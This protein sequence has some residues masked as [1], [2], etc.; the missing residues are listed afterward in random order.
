MFLRFETRDWLIDDRRKKISDRLNDVKYIFIPTWLQSFDVMSF[1]KSQVRY[2]PMCTIIKRENFFSLL[3][4]QIF[5]FNILHLRKKR[6]ARR[7]NKFPRE[8]AAKKFRFSG[9]IFASLPKF[10]SRRPWTCNN[11]VD[12]DFAIIPMLF[13]K[14]FNSITRLN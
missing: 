10:S 9:A 7:K 3:N 6:L 14:R 1:A 2:F 12:F 5:T 11:N 8:M 4:R 13:E